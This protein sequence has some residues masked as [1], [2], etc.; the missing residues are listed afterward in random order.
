MYLPKLLG[1]LDQP[2]VSL[3]FPCRIH[4]LPN[5]WDLESLH[6]EYHLQLYRELVLRILILPFPR[7]RRPPQ[8][9]QPMNWVMGLGTASSLHMPH[10]S[11]RRAIPSMMTSRL[12][13]QRPRST[14]TSNPSHRPLQQ[15]RP[16]RQ[17]RPRTVGQ[18]EWETDLVQ[19]VVRVAEIGSPS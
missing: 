12:S 19:R 6:A 18:R 2:P 15:F 4:Q 11:Q 8:S 14:P 7:Q 13:V 10:T 5:I 3:F 16:R 1:V 9:Y 17:R